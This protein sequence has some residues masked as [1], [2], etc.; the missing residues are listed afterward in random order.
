MHP[1][2]H[3]YLLAYDSKIS[4]IHAYKNPW[5]NL[6]II[7]VVVVLL[8]ETLSH[9][10]TTTTTTT[11]AKTHAIYIVKQIPPGIKCL[12]ECMYLQGGVW[13]VW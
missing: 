11:Y 3:S 2:T 5:L 10:H 7:V 12:W 13:R 6:F 4:L 8:A 1:Y 9:Y